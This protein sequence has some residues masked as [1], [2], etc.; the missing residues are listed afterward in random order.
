MMRLLSLALVSS[1]LRSP[2]SDDGGGGERYAHDIPRDRD[3]GLDVVDLAK[4]IA[5]VEEQLTRHTGE[6]DERLKRMEALG[7]QL[8]DALAALA[9][10]LDALSTRLGA[11]APGER[12][13][14]DNEAQAV[15]RRD[16]LGRKVR[17]RDPIG[18][19]VIRIDCSALRIELKHGD[20]LPEGKTCGPVRQPR[21]HDEAT[22]VDVDFNEHGRATVDVALLEL[23][24]DASA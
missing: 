4:E 9:A 8:K 7:G 12:A 19:E 17:V 1:V 21:Y 22:T 20:R 18:A 24:P 5:D 10:S 6:V 2:D 16:E 3:D 15:A 11:Q 14:L 23:V 13:P